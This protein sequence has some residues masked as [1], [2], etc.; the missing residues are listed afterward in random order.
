[1]RAKDLKEAYVAYGDF[2]SEI[3]IRYL[4]EKIEKQLRASVDVLK[5]HSGVIEAKEMK[6][7][8]A[9]KTSIVNALETIRALINR[10]KQLDE[11]TY[12]KQLDRFAGD[13]ETF[14]GQIETILKDISRR[15]QA[16][17]RPE[18]KELVKELYQSLRKVDIATSSV[19]TEIDAILKPTQKT[20]LM[21]KLKT[22]LS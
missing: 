22:A 3:F 1:M 18:H 9:F 15:Y 16:I 4:K 17:D 8:N 6:S 10:A 19:V 11:S 20:G 12:R 21:G 2:T 7:L 13:L 14:G 5:S